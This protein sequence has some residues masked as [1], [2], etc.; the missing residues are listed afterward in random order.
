MKSFLQQLMETYNQRAS[1]DVDPFYLERPAK[2][3][4]LFKKYNITS[5]F[6]S[7]CKDLHWMRY[8]DLKSC[9]INYIGG[10]ISEHMVKLAKKLFTD[11]LIIHH[12]CTSDPLP[13]VDLLLSSDVM[14]HLNNIDRT[15]FLKNFCSSNIQYLLMTDSGNSVINE[16]IVY[17]NEFPMSHVTWCKEPWN[18]PLPLD[19][20]DDRPGDQRLRLWNHEQLKPIVENL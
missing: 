12:D 2:L 7:G 3:L 15:K 6:D 14:I 19:Y 10:D 8:V 9:G 18:F 1:E 17:G 20:I 11:K 16:D 5:V 4:S 13:D